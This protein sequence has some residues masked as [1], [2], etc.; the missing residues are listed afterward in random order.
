MNQV[1][2]VALC[3]FEHNGRRNLGDRFHV[4]AV[5]AQ[6]LKDRG[7]VSLAEDGEQKGKTA[8]ASTARAGTGR[9]T[10]RAPREKSTTAAD[11]PVADT[12]AAA[13]NA[14]GQQPAATPPADPAQ[15]GEG[16]TAENVAKE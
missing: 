1:E 11:K 4:S 8:A 16:A 10:T 6:A 13:G 5:H 3:G 15:A 14:D 7:L 12:A 2:V 9:G